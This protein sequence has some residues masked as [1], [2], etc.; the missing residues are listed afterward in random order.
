MLIPGPWPHPFLLQVYPTYKVQIHQSQKAVS[1]AT[2]THCAHV[3]LARTDD[4][5]SNSTPSR[6]CLRKLSS[7][8]RCGWTAVRHKTKLFETCNL[9]RALKWFNLN[10]PLQLLILC[11]AHNI[12]IQSAHN[13]ISECYVHFST[14]LAY[15]KALHDNCTQAKIYEQF[16]CDGN[17]GYTAD[18]IIHSLQFTLHIT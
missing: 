13:C 15:H 14:P 5:S 10:N 12:Y 16:S 2:Y 8:Y 3:V 7:G 4:I 11:E 9:H 1:L 6:M 18:I 17:S